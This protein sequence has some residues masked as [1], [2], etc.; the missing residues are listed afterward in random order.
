[1]SHHRTMDA[2]S[3]DLRRKIVEAVQQRRMNKSEAAA[4]LAGSLYALFFLIYLHPTAA[5]LGGEFIGRVAEDK[6]VA[7]S[8]FLPLALMFAF[9]FLE[10]RKLRYLMVFAFFCW[11]VV[12]I[13]PAGLAIIGLSMA[14][15]GLF[16]LAVNWRK[17][18]AWIRTVSL[19]VPLV[20]VLKRIAMSLVYEPS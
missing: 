4:L 2:Y 7:R 6:F 11:A 19:G 5:T 20:S 9:L 10:S 18:Q 14:G 12:A 8:L 17:K 13:H 1:M 16:H 3:E 15:F